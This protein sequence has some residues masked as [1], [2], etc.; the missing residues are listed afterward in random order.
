MAILESIRKR[1][2]FLILVIGLALFAFVI[3]GVFTANGG[4]F[5][6]SK[7]IIGKINGESITRDD[8]LRKVENATRTYGANAS[9]IQ[10]VNQVWN[11]EMR[12]TLLEQQ[13]QELGLSIEK[14]QIINVI[15]TNPAFSS[16]PTFQNENGVFDE[17]IF[18][19]FISN[20]R[21]DNPFGYQ[22]W[23]LQ[24]ENLVESA[25]EQMY[26]NLVK[27]GVVSTLKEGELNYKLEN[28]KVDIK[29]VQVPFSSILDSTINVSKKDI[30]D[31]I[32]DHKD[33]YEEDA[34]R[35]I[36]YVFFEEKPS[37]DDEGE[38]KE[39]LA[40]LLDVR[41]EFSD[42]IPSFKDANN[43]EEFVAKN[44]DVK[45]LDKYVF[46][47]QLPVTVAD[48]LFKLAINDVYGP[49]KD[50][51]D[52][53]LS[54]II[55]RTRI[56]D[57]VKASYIL[58]PY[59]GSAAAGPT[60]TKNKE[61][62]KKTID[63]LF[64]LVRNDKAKFTEVADTI[65]NDATRGK[66]GDLGWKK[67]SVEAINNNLDKDFSD[68]MFFN[69]KGDIEVIESDFGF[70]IIQIDD[71]ADFKD[72]VKVASIQRAIEPSEKTINDLFTTTTKFEIEAN[73]KDFQEVAKTSNYTVRP[74]NKIKEL[75]EVLP[76]IGNQRSIIQWAFTKETKIGDVKRFN[77]SNG[78]AVVRVTGKRKAGI[79]TA[80]EVSSR[81][82]PIIRRQ[83]KAAMIR[84][85]SNATSL[86]D[87][88]TQN[89]ASVSN[90]SALSMQS[91]TIAGAG[92][93]PKVLGA[94]F[95]LKDGEVSEMIDGEN[96][97]YMVQVI[98]RTDA[99]VLDNYSAYSLSKKTINRNLV[100]NAIFN[101]LRKAA[102]IEDNRATFY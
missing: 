60:T 7:S 10:V 63:S 69:D 91:T 40:S 37:L 23:K 73:E 96:G 18:I 53:K 45:Y 9:T 79:A 83:R 6:S 36:Q 67:Y 19:E 2:L 28:D 90:A 39:K 86:E 48:T 20:L 24:E 84:N 59:Q 75:D 85:K 17:G 92:R 74:V 22:Q 47:N 93:E 54:R 35:N 87:F 58:V 3:S 50:E 55:N 44:S 81:V 14:D 98:K 27:A 101:A 5:S 16:D 89:G 99:P 15:K 34:S 33:L 29:F 1:S 41:Y 77:L 12:G 64:A 95:G 68:F 62:A 100:N 42:T 76:G 97:V 31:Y 21:T 65:N 8:F 78:Y 4:G 13:F 57:S 71:Q 80:D 38:V 26:Y 32:N 72:A 102:D 66:G 82:L 30:Q 43:I 11:N 94:A 52:Y 25:K 46:K 56:A 49:Y 51:S 88:A 70:F 61:E